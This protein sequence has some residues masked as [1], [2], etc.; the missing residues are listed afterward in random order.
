[1]GSV[2]II[3]GSHWCRDH[4]LHWLTTAIP[5]QSRSSSCMARRSGWCPLAGPS[6]CVPLGRCRGEDTSPRTLPGRRQPPTLRAPPNFTAPAPIRP[7]A[8]EILHRQEKH[9][10]LPIQIMLLL[11]LQFQIALLTEV[12]IRLCS[13]LSQNGLDSLHTPVGNFD[14]GF[15]HTAVFLRLGHDKTR[16]DLPHFHQ[17]WKSEP[18]NFIHSC[19]KAFAFY[20]G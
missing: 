1:M 5:S 4:S 3:Q 16:S 6:R 10:G 12:I 11:F 2:L 20:N 18:D 15:S 19:Y 9:R 8:Y 14:G 7:P 17:L 13:L